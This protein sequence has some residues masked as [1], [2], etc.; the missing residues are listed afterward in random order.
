MRACPV[1]AAG[2]PSPA[3]TDRR[4]G[5][6][7]LLACFPS[8]ARLLAA[9]FTLRGIAR[10]IAQNDAPWAGRFALR[11]RP[12]ARVPRGTAG[13]S[14]GRTVR[15]KRVDRRR[16]RQREECW[17][18]TPKPVDNFATGT[19]GGSYRVPKI[20]DD[21][22]RNRKAILPPTGELAAT[23]KP[24]NPQPKPNPR[25]LRNVPAFLHDDFKR[26]G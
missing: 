3:L 23:Q 20:V 11:A 8:L 1:A 21:N 14:V 13:R 7:T 25:P 19:T 16:R 4:T 6:R 22:R 5:L 9:I 15:P 17:S 26:P 18:D 12:P 2:R 24:L 10:T